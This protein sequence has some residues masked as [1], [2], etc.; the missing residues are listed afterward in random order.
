VSQFGPIYL[1][2][3]LRGRQ[4]CSLDTP[5]TLTTKLDLVLWHPRQV[6][7]CRISGI[8]IIVGG[9]IWYLLL[10]VFFLFKDSLLGF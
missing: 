8:L 7:D 5:D 9:S 2:T 3:Y 1:Q 6:H 4:E 10:L